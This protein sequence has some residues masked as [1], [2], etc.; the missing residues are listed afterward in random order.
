MIGGNEDDVD[1]EGDVFKSPLPRAFSRIRKAPKP[2]QPCQSQLD[3]ADEVQ[4]DV[5]GSVEETSVQ[6]DNDVTNPALQLKSPVRLQSG[7]LTD[8]GGVESPEG[9]TRA[10]LSA[11]ES[12]KNLVENYWDEE[13]ELQ[14]QLELSQQSNEQLEGKFQGN[15]QNLWAPREFQL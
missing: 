14:E 10:T 7:V 11:G 15:H 9:G 6:K 4:G 12:D 1:F 2:A 5:V 3:A 8:V 13:D